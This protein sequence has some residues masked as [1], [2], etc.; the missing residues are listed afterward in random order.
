ML[1]KDFESVR[2]MFPSLEEETGWGA[3][4][5]MYMAGLMGAFFL[6]GVLAAK[7][8]ALGRVKMIKL[9]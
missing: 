8:D 9:S 7:M 5:R 4:R 1:N 6:V 3:H 2:Q